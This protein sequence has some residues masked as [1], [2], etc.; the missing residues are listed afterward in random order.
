MRTI[1]ELLILLRDNTRVD[2]K[3]KI[4]SGLCNEAAYIYY[5]EH[6]IVTDEYNLLINFIELNIPHF[7]I[8]LKKHPVFEGWGVNGFGWI[9]KLWE[10][11]LKWLN[12]HIKLTE[13]KN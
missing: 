11:R 10:P 6:L 7:T 9:P 8:D 13:P 2:S 1:H 4:E 5:H 3:G 12:K